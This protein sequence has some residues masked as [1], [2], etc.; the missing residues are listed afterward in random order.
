WPPRARS[1]PRR[2]TPPPRSNRPPGLPAESSSVQ[3]S[4]V[5]SCRIDV[6]HR[7]PGHFFQIGGVLFE[8]QPPHELRL[9][10]ARRMA[11]SAEQIGRLAVAPAHL[12]EEGVARFA[13]PRI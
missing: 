12:L 10:V 4:W 3:F 7:L 2:A 8:A 9:G 5:L 11:Q 13:Q 1:T 6:H